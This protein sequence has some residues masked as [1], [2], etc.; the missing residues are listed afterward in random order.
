MRPT[1]IRVAAQCSR[2]RSFDGRV[3]NRDL[4]LSV[5][6]SVFWR[7]ENTVILSTGQILFLH[8]IIATKIPI[9]QKMMKT[10]THALLMSSSV[11]KFK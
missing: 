10:P 4:N 6:V 2:A 3:K 7:E 1:E 8:G 11:R 9:Q 5:A